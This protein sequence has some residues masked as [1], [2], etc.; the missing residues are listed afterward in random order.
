MRLALFDIDGTLIGYGNRILRDST[1][2]ALHALKERGTLL[3]IATARSANL[4]DMNLL[5]HISF[6]YFICV[7][8]TA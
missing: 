8:S 5:S 7:N 4:L 6:D 2:R 1:I 3:V